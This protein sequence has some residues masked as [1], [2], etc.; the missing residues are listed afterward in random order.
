MRR[1][2]LS[3][4]AA[5]ALPCISKFDMKLELQRSCT[6]TAEQMRGARCEGAAPG[7]G[8][9]I[10]AV[11]LTLNRGYNLI[12]KTMSNFNLNRNIGDDYDNAYDK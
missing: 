2:R 10:G 1:G 11:L 9:A 3:Q 4:R 12:F 5:Q 6:L 8:A 7:K